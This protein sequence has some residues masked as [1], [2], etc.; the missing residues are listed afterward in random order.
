MAFKL[1]IIIET[2]KFTDYRAPENDALAHNSSTIAENQLSNL[3]L[4][5]YGGSTG[6]IAIST[7]Q[8]MTPGA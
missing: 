1:S 3:Q 2:R 8:C 5:L 6:M 7:T 4:S